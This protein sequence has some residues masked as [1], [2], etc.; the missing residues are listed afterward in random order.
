[1]GFIR[2]FSIGSGIGLVGELFVCS[3]SVVGGIALAFTF[4]FWLLFRVTLEVE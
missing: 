2:G 1:M 3:S 4:S